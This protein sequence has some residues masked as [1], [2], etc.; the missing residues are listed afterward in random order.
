MLEDNHLLS[1]TISQS[2]RGI[3]YRLDSVVEIGNS[4]FECVGVGEVGGIKCDIVAFSMMA[5]FLPYNSM[6]IAESDQSSVIRD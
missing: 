5:L 3:F 6:C 4:S 2:K 1:Q